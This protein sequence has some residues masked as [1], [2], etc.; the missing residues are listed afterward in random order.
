MEKYNEIQFTKKKDL[1]NRKII[2]PTLQ[3]YSSN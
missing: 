1:K 2:H 3:N